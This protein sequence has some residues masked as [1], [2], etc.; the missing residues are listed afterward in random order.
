MAGRNIRQTTAGHWQI[1]WVDPTGRRRAETHHSQADAKLALDRHLVERREVQR[2]LRR[3]VAVDRTFVELAEEWMATRAQTK[4]SGK[5]DAEFVRNH[6]GP[7]LGKKVVR[8]ITV[9]DIERFKA[10]KTRTHSKKTVNLFLGLLNAMLGLA[11][12]LDWLD[13]K[14]KVRLHRIPLVNK[15]YKYLRTT[16]EVRS[17]L[18]AARN[19]RPLRGKLAPRD[20]ELV[21]AF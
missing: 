5:K 4:R 8:N 11:V 16:E 15:N 17:F 13:R 10:S 18:A 3:L 19:V 12:E 2:G 7:A 6:L 21:H 14:P 9:G 20:A 1:R